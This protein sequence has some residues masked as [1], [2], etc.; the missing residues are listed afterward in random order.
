MAPDPGFFVRTVT[1]PPGALSGA[2]RWAEVTVRSTPVSGT[3]TVATAIEQ[4]D[5][6]S[7]GTLMWAFG[8]GFHEPE[9]DNVRARSWRWM[10]ERGEIQVAQAAGDATLLLRGEAPLTYFDSPST[11]EVRCGDVVLGRVEL[12]G[13]FVVR[14]G[15]RE[16]QLQAGDGR[17][18]L[19]TT[20][21]FAPAERSGTNDR[22][23]LGL[24]LFEVALTPG[25]QTRASVPISSQN[26]SDLR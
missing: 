7:A 1:L 20:Q 11:L 10:S 19:T 18:V 13:D 9:L 24:R 8:P 5:V 4:F 3:A 17:I 16:A 21:T 23:R 15:V 26:T 12:S 25:L 22:R 2:G 6:Q 14:L